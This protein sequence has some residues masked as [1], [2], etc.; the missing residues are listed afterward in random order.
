[1]TA[2][3]F[4]AL[5]SLAALSGRRLLGGCGDC[6]AEQELTDMGDG[7]FVLVVRHAETC[8]RLNGVTS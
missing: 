4:P 7:V 5:S 8:P 6:D 3:R 2:P 1:M